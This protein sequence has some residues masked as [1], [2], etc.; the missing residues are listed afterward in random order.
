M[1]A[2]MSGR[3]VSP[4]FVGRGEAL[5]AA[6][7]LLQR[8]E[9]A[10]PSHL[11]V[12]GEA[13]IGKTRFSE[14]VGALAAAQGFVV[15]RGSCVQ[16]GSGELP[17]APIAEAL[18]RLA[19]RLDPQAL[20]AV[21]AEDG[22]VLSRITPA[23]GLR[24]VHALDVEPT[25][26][27]RG[28]LM[29]ALLGLLGRLSMDAPVLLIVEDLHWADS[30]TLD[31]LSFL[32]RSLRDER[33]GLLLTFRSD[34]LHRRHPLRPWLGEI[35]RLGTVERIELEALAAAE[36][37]EL[38]A[39]IRGG[40]PPPELIERIQARSDGNPFFIEEL[41]AREESQAT[42]SVLRPSLRDILLSRI[43]S[44]PDDAQTILDVAAVVGR[45]VDPALLAQVSALAPAALDA[46]LDACVA[47][48][49]LVLDRAEARER[50]A[51]RH[52]LIAEV[53]YDGI[54]P[55]ERIRL[56]RAIAEVLAA[57]IAAPGPEVP[58]RWAELAGHW[59]AARDEVRAFVAA[60]HAAEEA[61]QAFA[62]AAAVAQYRR[63][64]AGWELVPD[65]EALAGYD[66]IELLSRAAT[67][68]WLGG[69]DVGG[70]AA[71][72]REA[73][74]EADR[75]GD[76]A[77]GS[78][79]RGRLGFDLWIGGHPAEAHAAYREALELVSADPPTVE[80][81]WI[82]ARLA[83]TLMLE[84]SERESARIAEEAIAI[85]RDVGDRRVEAHALSTLAADL[86]SL[87]RCELGAETG[88]RSVEIALELE[89]PR[90]IG[91]AYGNAV[92][93]LA[94]CGRDDR[95]LELAQ[96]G[97]ERAAAMGIGEVDAALLGPIAAVVDYECGRW[98]EA[99]RRLADARVEVPTPDADLLSLAKWVEILALTPG[100]DV[101]TGEWDAA[102]RKLAWV[103]EQL[104]DRFESE[105]QYTG[106]WACAR[107]ELALW[108]ARPRDALVA[109]DEVL[110]RLE[111]TDDV[112]YR[113]RLLRL[114][115]R[116][117]ADLAEIARDRG[118][119]AAEAE[120]FAIAAGLR[121]R[122]APAV[123]AIASM[124]GGLELEL[125]AEEATVAAEETRL[126]GVSDPLAWREAADR[127]SA[128][129][130]P[131]PHA[132]VRFREAEASLGRG[133]RTDATAALGEAARIATSLGARPLLDAAA[134]LA[135]RARIP[136]EQAAGR[137]DAPP[138]EVDEGA[139]LAAELGLT[140]REREV[141]ELLAQGMTNRQ[142]ADSLYISVYT[143]G[144]HVSRILGK[145]GV[146]SRTEAAS[147][148]YR[149][150]LVAR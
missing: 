7:A 119:P 55:D 12:A 4:T 108:Q 125:R 51:F 65:P 129:G 76:V 105:Y 137:P 57:R 9:A 18:R 36:T 75:R 115:M 136:L 84:G 60:L 79:L 144:I 106:P 41:L 24:E 80:R 77:R 143:A 131:Y 62:W 111:R 6:E 40:E 87:G 10:R 23:L 96:E 123:A 28:Q 66:R 19:R 94:L 50:L 29:E 133:E 81:G 110:P 141:L 104:R 130:R 1:L 39:A 100:L 48:R 37:G 113:M 120:A 109:V 149:L 138:S 21:V 128:R 98:P 64:L 91:R 22:A 45:M 5:A 107:A 11:L 88:E 142:I 132:Y 92:E 90:Y 148:A 27:A 127:W 61:E 73:I 38:I 122:S 139:A 82:L 13:G 17:Y 16:L 3:L 15:L 117:A 74:A 86:A 54:L 2:S 140:S 114:G 101:G 26:A 85:A 150:G 72:L 32:L 112:R 53:V 43:E 14:A 97:V 68:T 33:V 134:G 102:E 78:L 116:A 58:G 121:A 147:K 8:L 30:A 95:A 42:P 44:V 67:A 56:H 25:E 47:R 83:Q 89:D 135:R 31:T 70:Q 46:G 99:A 69:R 49:L 118:D 34:E 35:E 52:A 126:H 59:E 103:G 63:A 93:I 20:A 146:A 124:D 145:L 71:L